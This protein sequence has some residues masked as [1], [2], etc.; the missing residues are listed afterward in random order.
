MPASI[1]RK[2]L[3]RMKGYGSNPFP[4]PT[5]SRPLSTAQTII[6]PKKTNTNG[7]DPIPLR[8]LSAALSPM[9]SWSSRRTVGCCFHWCCQAMLDLLIQLDPAP[10]ARTIGGLRMPT[11]V[12]PDSPREHVAVR[13]HHKAPAPPRNSAQ[14]RG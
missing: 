9:E 12:T 6:T 5:W 13:Q 14:L 11:T 2:R 10:M 3:S 1:E 8:I 4:P 7:H